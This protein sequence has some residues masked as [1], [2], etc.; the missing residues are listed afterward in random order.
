M[1]AFVTLTEMRTRAR[2]LA[3]M[4]T[5]NQAQAFI[6]DAELTRALNRN[7]KQL[8]QKLIAARGD[9][10]YAKVTTFPSQ[11]GIATYALPTDFMAL[12]ML[13][14]SDGSI[15]VPV[16]RFNLKQ[17][18]DLRYLQ[19]VQSNDLT[20]Y[21]YRPLASNI[22]IRPAPATANHTFTMYYLPAFAELVNG[23]DTFDGINGW[24]DWA[25]YGAAID[26]LNKEES[27]DQANALMA[28]RAVLDQQIDQLAG[29]RD[30]GMPET[31]GDTARDWWLAGVNYLRNDWNW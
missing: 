24:E 17:W 4:Q 6:T 2:E 9:D 26:M 23:S 25:I 13:A 5:S 14:V 27:Y 7:I 1:A 22:E 16:Q 29:A 8:Y 28:Q 19:N 20:L 12:L 3:D 18:A 21:R 15:V 31:W 30:A 10:Y 11:V